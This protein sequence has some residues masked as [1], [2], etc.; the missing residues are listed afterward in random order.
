MSTFEP[1]FS[2]FRFEFFIGC[3]I[4][5]FYLVKMRFWSVSASDN[6]SLFETRIEIMSHFFVLINLYE[7]LGR[8]KDQFPGQEP[9]KTIKFVHWNTITI[10]DSLKRT[11]PQSEF[12]WRSCVGSSNLQRHVKF[13]PDVMYEKS[14]K[15]GQNCEIKVDVPKPSCLHGKCAEVSS[16]HANIRLVCKFWLMIYGDEF[17]FESF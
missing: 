6:V 1:E 14:L 12:I 7:D 13:V 8:V 5:M 9:A 16:D 15:V 10:M 3:S 17:N 4:R 11:I 2:L